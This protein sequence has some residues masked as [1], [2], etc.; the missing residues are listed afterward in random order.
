MEQICD[1]L[2]KFVLMD[3]QTKIN[4]LLLHY[5]R[6]HDEFYVEKANV[7]KTE[8]YKTIDMA[9]RYEALVQSGVDQWDGFGDAI[10][11]YKSWKV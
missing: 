2:N 9:E 4:D 5:K 1:D 6:G 7:M 11:L 10:E 3:L 8:L